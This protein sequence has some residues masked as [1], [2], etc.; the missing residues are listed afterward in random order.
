LSAVEAKQMTDPFHILEAKGIRVVIDLRVGHVRE[1]TIERGGRSISPL[2]TA[3]WVEDSSITG[4]STLPGNLRY[5]SGDF[6]CAPFSTSDVENA[7][8]HGWPANSAWKL[9]YSRRDGASMIGRYELERPVMGARVLKEFRLTD[10][11]PF[12]YQRHIFVG[13]HGATSVAN[14]A[15]IRFAGQGALAFSK[16]AYGRTPSIALE[17]DPTRGRSQLVYPAYFEDLKRVPSTDGTTVDLTR[18]PIGR[19]HEDFVMLVENRENKIG[20]V[21]ALRPDRGDL[22]LSLK[23]PS[24]LPVTFLWYSNGGRDYRPWNSRHTGVLGVEEGCSYF[25]SG[26]RA[27]VEPNDLSTSGV[28]TAIKLCANQELEVR[29]V[30]GTIP[31]KDTIVGVDGIEFFGES[32]CVIDLNGSR[33]TVPWDGIFLSANPLRSADSENG[34]LA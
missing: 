15:M 29:N 23:D 28:Q 11:H 12:L 32:L 19:R 31:I 27:S 5:L 20:W 26:H 16:K 17:T 3:P 2:H 14:H 24:V 6:F 34:A 1:L 25:G 10:H 4:D 18:Y 22:F 33:E 30:I 21:S 9:Q 13:G 7:P 8:P